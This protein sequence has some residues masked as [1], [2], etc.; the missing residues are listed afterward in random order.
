MPF[1]KLDSVDNKTVYESAKNQALRSIGE[2]S[3]PFIYSDKHEFL[4]PTKA[5]APLFLFETSTLDTKFVSEIKKKAKGTVSQGF[6]YRN[7]EKNLVLRVASGSISES[8]FK[9]Q[10]IPKVVIAKKDGPMPAAKNTGGNPI[11]IEKSKLEQY[12]DVV[13]RQ[14]AKVKAAKERLVELEIKKK[15]IA[16]TTKKL[17]AQSA[18]EKKDPAWQLAMD[19]ADQ[20]RV[21]ASEETL[22]QRKIVSFAEPM[23]KKVESAKTDAEKAA[24]VFDEA[25]FGGPLKELEGTAYKAMKDTDDA[26]MVLGRTSD[27]WALQMTDKEKAR[28]L[29]VEPDKFTLTANDAFMKGGL[30]IKARFHLVSEFK[31]A[32]IEFLKKPGINKTK[33]LE[34]VEKTKDAEPGL[35]NA[36]SKTPAVSARELAQLFEDGYWFGLYPDPKNKGKNIQMMFPRSL[37]P[38]VLE[39]IRKFQKSNLKPVGT[40]TT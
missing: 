38:D 25:K 5:I 2:K 16:E 7:E 20:A 21:S 3:I 32:T 6:C 18:E 10:G 35:W 34:F 17:N 37:K 28:A 1:F 26:I 29:V 19:A 14:T 27:T 13:K 24:I 15:E 31:P 11:S 40:K 12:P 36:Q 9:I 33:F 30:D 8:T 23:L 4:L 39:Q 22:K